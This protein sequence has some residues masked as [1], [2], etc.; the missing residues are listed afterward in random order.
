MTI[1]LT[2]RRP[3]NPLVAA[4]RARKAGCHRPST[5]ALRQRHQRATRRALDD[6]T[7]SP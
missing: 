2:L 5:G 4:A 1:T 7:R 6:M 3:R